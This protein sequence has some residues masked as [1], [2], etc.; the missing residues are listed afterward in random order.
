VLITFTTRI[1]NAADKPWRV[2]DDGFLRV[3]ARILAPGVYP[4]ALDDVPEEMRSNFAGKNRVMERIPPEEISDPAALASFEGKPV[5]TV[6]QGAEEPHDWRNPKNVL[7]DGRTVGNV[8]GAPYA[9]ET[10]MLCDLL[11]MDPQAI[12]DVMAGNVIEVNAAYDSEIEASSADSPDTGA[13]GANRADAV[14]RALRGNHVLL[15]PEGKGR[16]GRTVRILNSASKGLAMPV[17]VQIGNAAAEFS[18]DADAQAAKTLLA[19]QTETL[20]ARDKEIAG[21]KA[22]LKLASTR[23]ENACNAAMEGKDPTAKHAENCGCAQCK[24]AM[25]PP[26]AG[27]H[28]EGS[29]HLGA[30]SQVLGLL[31][32]AS[33]LVARLTSEEHQEQVGNETAA[34]KTGEEKVVAGAPEADKLRAA[35]GN[36]KTR[37]ERK[38]VIVT[39]VMNARKGPDYSKRPDADVNTAFEVLTLEASTPATHRFGMPEAGPKTA[40]QK[41]QNADGTQRVHPYFRK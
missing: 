36:C 26:A 29:E 12:K 39:H 27:M 19:A 6:P 32:Q 9:D 7:K 22:G 11:I 41:T 14:Q 33:A 35:I 10:G 13:T 20:A 31:K 30:F 1:E 25:P 3:T 38:R 23:I 8:A 24:N 37:S 5:C 21:L 34:Y 18:T 15:L 16:C 40:T 17:K 2:D 28:E 4:Y